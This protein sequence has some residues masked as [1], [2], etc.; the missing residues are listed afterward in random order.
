M[1]KKPLGETPCPIA[2][3]AA[4]V[5]DSWS[6]L[7]LREAFYGVT[8]FDEFQQNLAI[9]PN[10]LTRRLNSL[11]EEGMLERRQYCDR[12]PRSEY[13]LTERGRDFRQVLLAMLAWGNKHLAP[14]GESVQLAN[15]RTGARVEPVLVDAANGRPVTDADYYLAPGP[16]ASD[17]VR[18]RLS[19]SAEA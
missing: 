13:I 3:T 6:V 11:V 7:I 14:E 18:Q 12:P 15:R 1:Q 10:M 16:A 17:R 2:R 9:A 8:R 19:R 5:A 4:R